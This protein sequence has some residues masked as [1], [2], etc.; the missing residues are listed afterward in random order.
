M[1]KKSF[2][3]NPAMTFINASKVNAQEATQQHTQEVA[4]QDA[5]E[6][7]NMEY[8]LYVRTQGRKGQKKPRINLAFDSEDF[9][10]NIRERADKNGMSITQLVNEAVSYYLDK[11]N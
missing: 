3:D 9:L 11:T 5:R 4:Q 10:N 6:V 7:E 8:R 2:K 1:A